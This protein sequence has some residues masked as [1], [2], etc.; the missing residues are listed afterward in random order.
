MTKLAL[1]S[2]SLAAAALLASSCAGAQEMIPITLPEQ[3]RLVGLGVFSVPDFY[4]SSKNQGAAAPLIRYQFEGTKMYAQLIGPEAQLN[5]VDRDDIRGGPLLRFRA[6]RD[7]D[8]DDEVVKRMRPV[9]SATE[10]GAF[11]AYHLPVDQRPLHKVVFYAD[12][13]GNT[14]NVYNGLTGNLRANYIYPFEQGLMGMPLVG[15]VGFNLFWTSKSFNRKYFGVSGSDLALYPEL[16]GQEY[17]PD[18]GLTSIKIPFSL[19]S[20]VSPKWLITVAGR[21]EQLLSDAK[22]SPIIDQHGDDKQWVFGI[23]ASY[24]F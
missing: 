24:L 7:D 19:S 16:G 17:R 14:T 22:D 4:G 12:V 21:Y 3:A 11:I 9:A 6:R 10:I 15:S 18:G 1:C 8:V 5:L 13:V 2:R 20:Q 23:A